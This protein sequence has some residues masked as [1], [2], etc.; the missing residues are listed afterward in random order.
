MEFFARLAICVGKRRSN[1]TGR[2]PSVHIV[3]TI[4][5]NVFSLMLRRS[6]I[7]LKGMWI[8]LVRC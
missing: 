1:V 6:A 2:C 4:R 8:C 3:L 5:R 7:R